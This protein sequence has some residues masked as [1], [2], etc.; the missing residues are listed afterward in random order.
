MVIIAERAIETV[1]ND[2]VTLFRAN[3]STFVPDIYA[4]ESTAYQTEI[5]NWWS[6][7]NNN[8]VVQIGYNLQKIQMPQLA[9]TTESSSEVGSRR[10]IGHTMLAMSTSQVMTTDFDSTYAIHVFGPNQNWLLWA[11]VFVKWALLM[12][13]KTLEQQYF[14]INQRISLSPLRPAPDS[15]KDV[16]FP[17]M[18]TVNLSCQ[19]LDSW[20]PLP[21]ATTTAA[22]VTLTPT[23]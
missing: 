1:L 9:I 10:P 7:A 8:V 2:A 4:Q 16:V 6:N 22:T 5:T 19:H 14:L 20:T 18:R 3:L 15:M 13:R 23:N 12:Y 17:F 11:Q 21:G